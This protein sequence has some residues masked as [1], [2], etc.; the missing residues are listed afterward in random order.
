MGGQGDGLRAGWVW[1]RDYSELSAKSPASAKATAP[2]A[3]RRAYEAE[4]RR[5][6]AFSAQNLGF[7]DFFQSF[8]KPLL[9][10]SRRRFNDI[11]GL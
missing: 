2:R 7:R 6:D 1:R 8:S 10:F 4:G 9:G 11:K 3:F 5:G